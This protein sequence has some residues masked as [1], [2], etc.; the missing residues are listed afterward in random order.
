MLSSPLTHRTVIPRRGPI[1]HQAE[2]TRRQAAATA[3]AAT[4]AGPEA[5]TVAVEVV[6]ATVVAVEAVLTVAEV[7]LVAADRTAAATAVVAGRAEEGAPAGEVDI[8][9]V[10][11][12]DRMAAGAAGTRTTNSHFQTVQ[13]VRNFRTGFFVESMKKLRF[14]SGHGFHRVLKNAQLSGGGGFFSALPLRTAF[15]PT[16]SGRLCVIFS[17]SRFNL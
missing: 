17:V 1:P 2:A 12:V 7:I 10:V 9:A 11:E 16:L 8:V 5:V 13:P 15:T 3:E 4:L 6:V 14:P